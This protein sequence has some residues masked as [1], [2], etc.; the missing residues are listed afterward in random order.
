MQTPPKAEQT[1]P[2][3]GEPLRI[4]PD[5]AKTGD[6]SFLEGCWRGTSHTLDDKS[7]RPTVTRFCFEKDGTG[8]QYR[9]TPR[10]ECTGPIQGN[11]GEQGRLDIAIKKT[12]CPQRKT[13]L[14]E[15]TAVCEIKGDATLCFERFIEKSKY[16]HKTKLFMVRE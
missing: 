4:P 12:P 13:S 10:G 8:K 9:E 11:F 16:S 1:Q 2:K 7:R 15:G 3:S 6:L 5:A 14:L